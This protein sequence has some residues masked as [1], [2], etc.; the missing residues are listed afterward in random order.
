MTDSRAPRDAAGASSTTD[1]NGVRGETFASD[2][3]RRSAIRA[4]EA[5]ASTD[6]SPAAE[7]RGAPV[8]HGAVCTEPSRYQLHTS[9]V[10]NGR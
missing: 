9:S 3:T 8:G 4:P 7:A 6:G 1:R 2:F 5:A 10:T